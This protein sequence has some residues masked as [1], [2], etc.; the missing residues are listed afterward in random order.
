M[1]KRPKNMKGLTSAN[2]TRTFALSLF[3]AMAL[4]AMAWNPPAGGGMATQGGGNA[5]NAPKAAACSPASQLTEIAYNNV[6]AVIENGGNFWQRR[7]Q[8]L[9]GYEV[10]KTED[11]TGPCSIFA[12]ALWM[13]GLS[14]AGQL[15][16][17]AVLYRTDGNDFW[18]GPLNREDASTEA[19]VCNEYDEFWITTRAQA[20]AHL[21][22]ANCGSDQACIDALF[23]NGYSVPETFRSWPALGDP[24]AGQDLYLAPFFDYDADGSYNP[25][26][27]DYPDYGFDL[28]VEDCKN[29]QRED[30]V[31]LFGDYNIFWI[32][33]DK[34]DAHTETQGQPIGLE[35]R[36]QAFAF[37]ANNEINNMTFYNYTVIN[38]AS[39]TLTNTYFGHFVDPDLGCSND[40]FAGCDVRRGLGYVYNWQ[41]VD[42]GCLGAVGYGGPAP[43]PPA[44]G[45][46]FF[47]G[48]FQ[49]ADG[50][51][52]PGPQS[53]LETYDCEQARLLH[54]IPYKGIGIGYGDGVADNER[55][56]MRAFIY[57]NR[58]SPNGN[59]TDPGSAPQFYNYLRS[60]W[61]NNIPQS[62]GGT[63]YSE[64]PNAIRAYY[65]FPGDS[66]PVGW[67]TDC[68]PQPPWSETVQTPATPDRRFVQSAGPFTLEAGAFN[69]ITVGV[70]WAR[71]QTGNAASSLGPLRVA[72]DK[73]Q[74][75]F[76]NCF[77]ILDGP[78][79]PD[80]SIR[81]LDQ[82]LIIYISN[83][84]GSNNENEQYH[85]VDPIIPL[86]NGAGGPPYDRE[87]KFE[88]YK[89][90]QMRSADASV[91]DI[92][93]DEL[94]RLVYQ[95]DVQNGVGQIVNYF[96]DDGIQQ[97]VP[98]A[99]VNGPD[100]GVVHSLRITK[101]FFAQG[102]NKLVN[103]KTYY[104]LC[105]AYGYNNYEDYN[106]QSGTGQPFPY[107]AGRKAAFGG[108]RS[109][110]GIPHKP[111]PQAGGTVQNSSYG[112]R[113]Q[114]TRLEGQGNGQLELQL[115]KATENAIVAASTSRVDQLTYELGKGP[116]EVKVVDPLRVPDASFE[117]WFADTATAGN[118]NDAFW[119]LVNT[120]T[121]D[122]IDSDRAID[123]GY[124]QLFPQYGISVT[125][126]QS[127]Y[128]GDYTTP[129]GT[130][131]IEF[132]DP[133][134][135]W[136]TGIP[137]ND[138]EVADNWIRSGT[139]VQEVT[140]P[141]VAVYS[142][143][144]GKD[145]LETYENILNGTWAPWP[146]VGEANFQ[147][148]SATDVNQ[149]MALSKINELPSV[150][151]VITSDKSKWTRAP[152]L[153][154]ESNTTLSVGNVARLALRASP[155]ID[156][157]GR[158]SGT[159]GCNENE[160]TLG[161]LQPT[162][163]GWFPGYAIDLETGERLNMGYGEN[164]F[165]GGEIGRDMIWNPNSQAFLPAPQGEIPT[166]YFGGGHWIYVW[167]NDRACGNADRVPNYDEARYIYTTLPTPGQGRLKVFRGLAWVGS[168]LVA[169]GKEFLST[170]VRIRLNV[171]KPYKA[172]VN[173]NGGPTDPAI[174]VSRNNG[175]PLYK[176]GTQGFATQTQVATVAEDFLEEINITPNPYY[177]FSG[178]ETSR[179]DNRVKFINLPQTCTISI[180]T[181]NGTLVRKFRKDNS[182][183]YVDWDLKNSNNIPI[184]GGVYICH[185]EVPGVG[186][187]VIKW[188]GVLR[189][190]DLQNF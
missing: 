79:A 160:A 130:G 60:I 88:G 106:L 138:G 133:S 135:A 94:A 157:N 98:V 125:I 58:S 84:T 183:T 19:D 165:W 169:P 63:G 46:D 1:N 71:S 108:I 30:P 174:D 92:G 162:G 158:K 85:E 166:P 190:L 110:V 11:F 61:K 72:D 178:Y 42:N 96:Y 45:V 116:I 53:Y 100:T 16:I 164:S 67:G 97:T 150:Q 77:K 122:T 119:Y 90:Y 123:I 91:A 161:N 167:K 142:D 103:F 83:P 117:V 111:Q 76:D 126:G 180:Y 64:D 31:P 38:W 173:Y 66:D 129:I 141:E 175:L 151:V 107:V 82:E 121:G 50:V 35:V 34:G 139:F 147:P 140:A 62:Y 73:A 69:N 134:K 105:I 104:Y 55:F 101:D 189:P 115:T 132:A 99:M 87:Y 21:A 171:E 137:D 40:D 109:Y 26:A 5:A 131:K 186:E 153:E 163:M 68:V 56:G 25:D 172:Y 154:Q 9:S 27:G 7:A 179:L 47:E 112:D 54:G 188:F 4:H 145:D 155:S 81:E 13:G 41:D 95:G 49:D 146:L 181:V 52:N 20:E 177:A 51:D 149:S 114:V 184:A 39:Q 18:P 3:A 86:D 124:E 156:K 75:L 8:G 136:L 6:R 168:A 118:L 10:P 44:V 29:K 127:Y 57:F 80:L 78:D 148:G 128:N 43:P 89:L 23:P 113:L 152:V 15:K 176:F 37:S 182:L 143:R 14:S 93:N 102:D 59:I 170:E 2:S 144:L 185:V 48:P 28:S 12:G 36:A 74:A 24:E 17:A 70:V 65:M 120:T 32:F 187:K 159:P 33:N 22:W